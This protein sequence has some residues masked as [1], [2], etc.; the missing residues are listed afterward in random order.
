MLT[1]RRLL[2]A[3]LGISIA[4]SAAAAHALTSEFTAGKDPSVRIL[5]TEDDG[6][7]IV[8]LSADKDICCLQGFFLDIGDNSLLEGLG[9]TGDD[10]T[11]YTVNIGSNKPWDGDHDWDQDEDRDK[12]K[13]KDKHHGKAKGHDKDKDRD[14]HKH[15][16][17]DD[18]DAD[19]EIVLGTQCCKDQL[20]E[21]TFVLDANEDLEIADFVDQLVAVRVAGLDKHGEECDLRSS[22]ILVAKVAEPIPEPATGLL[23]GFGMAALRYARN[24]R[25]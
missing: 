23:V 9:V 1:Q 20:T 2:L 17:K 24:R 6:D 25:R 22:E 5:L 19:I 10:V 18:L 16:K 13:H 4:L 14:K 12:D 11:S 8:S 15:D 3:A 21:T 7:I